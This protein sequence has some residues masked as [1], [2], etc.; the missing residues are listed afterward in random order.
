MLGEM[1]EVMVAHW[2]FHKTKWHFY[3]LS[4]QQTATFLTCKKVFQ[5][6]KHH[7]CSLWHNSKMY[8]SSAIH[9]STKSKQTLFLDKQPMLS[10]FLG[11]SVFYGLHTG[12]VFKSSVSCVWQSVEA[13]VLTDPAVYIWTCH[14]S[15]GV[16]NS[17]CRTHTASASSV[18]TMLASQ[19]RSFYSLHLVI[20]YT[21]RVGAVDCRITAQWRNNY[22]NGR[23]QLEKHF[24]YKWH[25]WLHGRNY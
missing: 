25:H 23:R 20:L 12:S 2:G 11:S 16:L 8:L 6:H 21:E 24:K 7:V 10:C 22:L 13:S 9:Y 3:H 5:I 1:I 15:D 17:V 4:V 18:D 19:N 14:C